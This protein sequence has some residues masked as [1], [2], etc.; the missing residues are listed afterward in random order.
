M[1]GTVN[2]I[3][4]SERSSWRRESGRGDRQILRDQKSLGRF[5]L[6]NSFNLIKIKKNE[7]GLA[8]LKEIVRKCRKLYGSKRKK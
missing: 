7:A 1:R 5:W 2:C 3:G 6:S 4:A 8:C